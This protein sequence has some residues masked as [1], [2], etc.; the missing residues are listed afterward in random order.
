MEKVAVCPYFYVL[1]KKMECMLRQVGFC[2]WE[3]V[4]HLAAEVGPRLV[5]ISAE[6]LEIL[7]AETLLQILEFR[8]IEVLE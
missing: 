7:R 8:Q 1:L 4:G 5:E 2:D 6:I 3:I